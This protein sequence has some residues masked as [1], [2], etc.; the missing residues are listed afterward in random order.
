MI[1]PRGP[2]FAAGITVGVLLVVLLTGS[3]W[4]ALAQAVIFGLS[5]AQPRLGPYGLVFRTLVAP[6][7]GPPAELEP[8]QPVR[9]A[10]VVGLIFTL[11]GAGGY[12]F[13]APLLGALAIAFALV[14]AFL[15]A[16]FGLCLGC[17]LYLFYRRLAGRPLAARTPR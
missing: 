14:A 13:N 4:L 5:A 12:L 15:N 9:F 16:V 17:E 10:Q 1:D 6:R 2:R 3:A 7:L 8:V 11:V